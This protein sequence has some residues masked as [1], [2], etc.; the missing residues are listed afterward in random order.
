MQLTQL[1]FKESDNDELEIQKIEKTT[2]TLEKIEFVNF[3]IL[4]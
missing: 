3:L 1:S 4:L 2:L